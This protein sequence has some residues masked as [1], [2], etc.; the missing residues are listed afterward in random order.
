MINDRIWSF[1]K[2]RFNKIKKKELRSIGRNN[3]PRKS[4]VLT[5]SELFYKDQGD[6]QFQVCIL[7]H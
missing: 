6:P 5:P 4:D 7:N 3:E 2:L 1:P